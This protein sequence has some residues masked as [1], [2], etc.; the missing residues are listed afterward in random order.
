MEY[1]KKSFSVNMPPGK[2]YRDNW[3]A[4]FSKKVRCEKCMRTAT[5]LFDDDKSRG[6]C[7]EHVEI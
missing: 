7:E 5:W 4:I 2:S 1:L 6:F 3:D